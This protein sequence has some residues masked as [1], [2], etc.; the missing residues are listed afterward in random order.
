MGLPEPLRIAIVLRYQ[1]GMLPEEI[2]ALLSQPVPTVK[3]HLRRGLELLR[4]KAPITL[5]EYVRG[6]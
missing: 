4:R 5:K 2:A 3:T 6:T 1:E